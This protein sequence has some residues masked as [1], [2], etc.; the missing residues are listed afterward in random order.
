MSSLKKISLLPNPSLNLIS[1]SIFLLVVLLF[2]GVRP[3]PAWS[4]GLW[5]PQFRSLHE[6]VPHRLV[7]EARQVRVSRA[8]GLGDRP[9]RP[10]G[11][12]GKE[13]DVDLFFYWL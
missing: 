12:S 1:L 6:E 8:E 9:R 5:L 7:A 10:L 4:L 11:S 3:A 13:R 2:V